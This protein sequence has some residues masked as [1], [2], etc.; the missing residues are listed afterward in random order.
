MNLQPCDLGPLE[1]TPDAALIRAAE[2][3][4]ELFRIAGQ[5]ALDRSKG[6]KTLDPE[7]RAWAMHYAAFKPLARPLGNGDLP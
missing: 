7:A 3:R 1:I 4:R 5:A 6:G 2:D